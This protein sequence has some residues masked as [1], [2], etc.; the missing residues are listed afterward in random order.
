PYA[1]PPVGALRWQPPQ[2]PASHP[3]LRQA[4]QFAPHCPQSKGFFGLPST[5]EDCLYLNVFAPRG[6]KA[7]ANLPVMVWIH[8]GAFVSGESDDY[9]PDRLVA[10]NT[11]VVTINY[12][13]G[14]LGFLG[15]TGL[16]A[17]RHPHIN[18]GILDQQAALAWVHANIASFGGNP[19]NTTTFGE[20]AGGYST[21][22]QIL[23]PGAAGLFQRA[24]VES[25]AYGILTIPTLQAAETAGNA[26]AKMAGCK[27]KD[28]A[29]LRA[30]SVPQ[31]LAL[32]PAG[33]S[34]QALTS[35]PGP[36]IDGTVIPQSPETALLAGSYN[37]VPIVQGSNH[38]EFR[39]FTALIF[40]LQD[41]PMSS[42]EY[43]FVVGAVLQQA[44]LEAHTAE[45]LAKYPL[46]NYASPDLAFS[47]FATDA[48]FSATTYITDSLLSV[49][50]PLYGY[51]FSDEKAPEEFLP[52][53]SF[54]Y[55]S[56]HASELQFL[57]DR[58][59]QKAP[60]LFFPVEKQLA[61]TMVGQWT[62]FAATGVPDA[63]GLPAWTP[64]VV[65]ADD[66]ESL[67]PPSPSLF[68]TFTREHK[69]LFWT[70]LLL[71]SEMP[72]RANGA[73]H[74][75]TLQKIAAAVA[76]VRHHHP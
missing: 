13:L 36:A 34:L 59:T 38:D 17:E 52:P 3:G 12:R 27:A 11:V 32:Q 26:I 14:Y 44:G 37:H 57:F 43:P 19:A 28:T 67:V 58:F 4:I 41:G 74:Y 2:P 50:T 15:T 69:T 1:A 40:D 9:D 76:T 46:A 73:R 63:I 66:V 60:P 6:T 55:A 70:K 51:E 33:E 29:C 49:G 75:I 72:L 39:L 47:A 5:D 20:S 48:A 10:G 18:Y 22:A 7:G 35:G 8:G 53:V 68:F 45:V 54:P 21:L 31:I 24:I 30:L 64:F 56:C 25:G 61:R 62:Q 42:E 65:P 71:A 16:D 23:S